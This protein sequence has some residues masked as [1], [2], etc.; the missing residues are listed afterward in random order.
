MRRYY[1]F[2]CSLILLSTLVLRFGLRYGTDTAL[3]HL[4]VMTIIEAGVYGVL[5]ATHL[6]AGRRAFRVVMHSLLFINLFVLLQLYVLILGSNVFWK[7]T[8]TFSVLKNYFRKFG[9]FIAS[10]PVEPWIFYFAY[11]ALLAICVGLYVVLRPRS[12]VL[13]AQWENARKHRQRIAVGALALLL[14]VF[15]LKTPL[16]RF[17]RI[18]QFGEEPVLQFAFGNLWGG[19]NEVAFDRQRYELG[20]RDAACFDSLGVRPGNSA[21]NVVVILLD[22]LR[23]D[24]LPAYGYGR[25]TAPFLDSLSRSGSLM[26]VKR[27]FSNST[28]TVGG[29]AGLFYSRDWESFGYTGLNLM[30]YLKGAGYTT[31][32]FL[33]GYHRDWFG[34]SALYR[35]S[36]DH[37]FESPKD[38]DIPPD[39]DMVTLRAIESAKLDRPGF[40]Y[41]HLLST[42]TI[43]KKHAEFRRF[44]PDKIG[45]GAD[46][47][48][49]LVNNYDNGIL[50]ADFVLRRLFAKFRRDGIL[51]DCTV[52][53]LADHGELFGE[54]GQWSHGGS[55]HPALLSIPL[56]I[57]DSNREW[58]R[59]LESATLK[60]IAP[61]VIDRIGYPV[62]ACWEGS[63]LHALPH[64]FSMP[65]NAV[66]TCDFPYGRLEHRDSLVSLLVMDP[67]KRIRQ[68]WRMDLGQWRQQQVP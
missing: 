36:S 39:D 68:K 38:P 37:Y 1:L 34:L 57:W 53:I 25:Q 63:S 8:I 60:D 26:K 21:H 30:K 55:V 40:L 9:D 52:F 10:M 65:V 67:Q 20:R 58:Y 31:Y 27:A 51:Q 11:G 43:G 33:T 17:K 35:S 32:A 28:N 18:M 61:T 47:R 14:A 48:T 42:H 66:S 3:Y 13:I 44:L 45:L 49:A 16:I 12:A 62:P 64:D 6:I 15:A 23:A 46:Q 41:I 50:Q 29:V 56:F 19:G 54:G 4:V 22:A 59:N 24:H 7:K 2:I 5:R